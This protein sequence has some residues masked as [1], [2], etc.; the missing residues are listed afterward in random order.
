M[1]SLSTIIW[2]VP[3]GDDV[4]E[5]PGTF[6]MWLPALHDMGRGTVGLG[7]AQRGTSQQLESQ[8]SPRVIPRTGQ[9]WEKS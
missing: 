5:A 8:G 3:Y 1:Y 9:I 4:S 2:P 7:R 6:L